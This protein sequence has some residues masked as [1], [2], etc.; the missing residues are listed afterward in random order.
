[1]N[2]N[3][4]KLVY[5]S[6]TN[7]T[8]TVLES[9]AQ[10]ITVDNIEHFDL[11]PPG[12]RTRNFDGAPDDVAIIG[13]PVYGGR[14]P[15]VALDRLKRFKAR[16]TPA[17]IV[18]L[19]GNREYEDALLELKNLAAEAG[20]IPVAGG[21]FIGEH[22]FANDTTPIANGRPDQEDRKKAKAFGKAISKK[23]GDMK[24]LE[25][26][27]PIE[28]PGNFPH[29]ERGKSAN[30]SPVTDS[31]TCALCETCASVCPTGAVTV[32]DS[33]VT[34]AEECI[35]CCACVKNCPTGA[36]IMEAPG[37]K[38]VANWLNTNFSK[39]KEPETYL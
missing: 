37:I 16:R 26:V 39:R 27:D 32:D 34:N 20:F 5:F 1:M 25:D 7:T 38:Q 19:Y 28:V 2:F 10:G 8:R 15:L 30:I 33:V 22:S 29:R 18:V 4:V 6:P 11:T 17:V 21:A 3:K 12:T 14:V 24:R 9:I 36:R 31:E 13:T 35:L 23:L